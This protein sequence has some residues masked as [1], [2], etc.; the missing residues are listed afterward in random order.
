MEA[1]GFVGQL[2]APAAKRRWSDAAK[3]R[4][5]AETLVPGVTVN[6]TA[7]W[8]GVKANHLSSC[9]RRRDRASWSCRRWRRAGG[10]DPDVGAA[11]R[12]QHN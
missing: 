8:L 1:F 4:M 9:G 11:S 6:D 3:G 10:G 12:D 7:R 5:V 2:A